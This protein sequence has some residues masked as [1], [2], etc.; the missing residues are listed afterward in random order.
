MPL[1]AVR[2]SVSETERMEV[3]ADVAECAFAMSV[4]LWPAVCVKVCMCE[5]MNGPGRQASAPPGGMKV[6]R[7]MGSPGSRKGLAS[8]GVH[9]LQP[10]QPFSEVGIFPD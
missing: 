8:E 6:K 2:V 9:H 4:Y 10:P 5:G 7:G 3:E 1:C